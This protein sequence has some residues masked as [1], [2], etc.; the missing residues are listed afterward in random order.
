M[1]RL[2]RG[3]SVR[4]SGLF[5]PPGLAMELVLAGLGIAVGAFTAFNPWILPV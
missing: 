1:L 3:H 2:G 5:S 4:A